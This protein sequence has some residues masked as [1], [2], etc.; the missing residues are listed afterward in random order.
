MRPWWTLQLCTVYAHNIA[1]GRHICSPTKHSRR[2]SELVA[3]P[4]VTSHSLTRSVGSQVSR[5]RR[6]CRLQRNFS[7]KDKAA[8][9]FEFVVSLRATGETVKRVRFDANA[10]Q[11]TDQ[12]I[13]LAGDCFA[14]AKQ[15]SFGQHR[16]Q[17]LNCIACVCLLYGQQN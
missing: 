8:N 16:I 12:L 5:C 13:E 15:L 9:G 3:A 1:L 4:P 6:R 7:D 10:M 17:L 11:E 14:F 2:L